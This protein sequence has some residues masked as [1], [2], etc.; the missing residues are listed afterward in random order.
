MSALPPKADITEG[1]WHV[2]F[3]P[4]ADS[5]GAAKAAYSTTSSARPPWKDKAADRAAL[6]LNAGRH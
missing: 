1:D 6:L 2:R 4:K 3:V 5:C